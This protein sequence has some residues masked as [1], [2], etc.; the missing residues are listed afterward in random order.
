MGPIRGETLQDS[1]RRDIPSLTGLRGVA[2]LWVV[3]FHMADNAPIPV[4]RFG[5]MGVDIFF[6][7]SG[8]V[9]SYVY[10]RKFTIRD[11]RSYSNF[12]QAR[13]ARIYPLHLV[14]LFTLGVIVL[15]APEH[16]MRYPTP[17][18]RWGIGSFFASIFLIQNWAHWLPTC[19]N[20][21][22][23]SLSAEFFAYLIFPVFLGVTQRWQGTKIPLMFAFG[24]LL[25]FQ[26]FMR[27]KGINGGN[28]TGTPGML[29]MVF[30]FAC[31]CLLYRAISNGLQPLP[32][33]ADLVAVGLLLAS[34]L[35]EGADFLAL[36]A[37]AVIVLLAAQ[38]RNLIACCLSV[39]PI[40][41]LGEISYSVYLVH[42]IILQ[43]WKWLW[44]GTPLNALDEI[45]W[46]GGFL[47]VV[48][49]VAT[50]TFHVQPARRWGRSLSLRRAGPKA[51]VT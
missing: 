11:F 1:G 36:P 29:R 32:L 30:E 5:Y 18:Q 45:A 31:G 6:I 42:W 17:E 49:L 41:F 28:V 16:F 43:L 44:A 21:P 13:I 15:C 48:L 23:W 51:E 24:S 14:T 34:F 4:I 40:V 26:L 38:D 39:A 3:F 37:F 47:A 19:W 33:V 50:V 35:I 8:F 25:L 7:L 9:L 10:A 12:I 27:T 20:T 22:S 46:G 2:A